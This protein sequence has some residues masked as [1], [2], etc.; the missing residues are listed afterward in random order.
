MKNQNNNLPCAEIKLIDS[1][2][3]SRFQLLGCRNLKSSI[4]IWAVISTLIGNIKGNLLIDDNMSGSLS[5]YEISELLESISEQRIY[6]QKKIAILLQESSSY[7]I[8]F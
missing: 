6:K 1:E 3:F 8:S 2:Q 7:K 5:T 4:N